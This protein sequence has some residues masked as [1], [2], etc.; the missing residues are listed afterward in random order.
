MRKPLLF[1]FFLSFL[2]VFLFP[3]SFLRFLSSLPF[4]C[5][6]ESAQADDFVAPS[7]PLVSAFSAHAWRGEERRAR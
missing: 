6:R 5:S 2:F 1:S 3:F 7:S 4:S